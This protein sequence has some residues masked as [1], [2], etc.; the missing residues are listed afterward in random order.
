MANQI[1]IRFAVFICLSVPGKP[2][3]LNVVNLSLD[4]LTL[5]WG[6]P[7]DRNGRLTGYTLKYQPGERPVA[8]R[9]IMILT[10]GLKSGM[11]I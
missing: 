4:S 11:R 10:I 7:H 8:Y 3:F 6:P 1:E 5:E 2:S 9:Q